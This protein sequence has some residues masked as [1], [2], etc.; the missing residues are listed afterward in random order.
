M[1]S[2]YHIRP[3]KVGATIGYPRSS[4]EEPFFVRCYSVHPVEK[5]FSTMSGATGVHLLTN[6]VSPAA[7]VYL[8]ERFPVR[9]ETT[10]LYI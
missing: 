2:P 5:F 10:S 1:T 3:P 8:G 7:G 4:L 6:G 9:P